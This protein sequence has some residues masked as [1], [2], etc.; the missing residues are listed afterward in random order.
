MRCAW[1][2][3]VVGVMAAGCSSSVDEGGDKNT[4]SGSVTLDGKP[5]EYGMI[6]AVGPD[7]RE[8]SGPRM[9]N[10]SYRI[11]NPPTGALKFKFAGG[12]P[13]APGDNVKAVAGSIPAKYLSTKN[14]LG[15]D[16]N[17]GRQKY[18]IALQPK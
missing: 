15:F 7:G 16:Y 10:G 1:L 3:V 12:P 11:V 9:A 18:D 6:V 8:V 5:A 13:P 14:E 4:L 2:L 17:G